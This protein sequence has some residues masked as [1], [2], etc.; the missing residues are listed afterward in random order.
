MYLTTTLS[1]CLCDDEFSIFTEGKYFKPQD[2]KITVT[3][4]AVC[5]AY[6]SLSK[7]KKVSPG[8]YKSWAKKSHLAA[9]DKKN[10]QKFTLQLVLKRLH[11]QMFSPQQVI[12]WKTDLI[13]W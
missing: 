8:R 13:F 10:G 12:P 5:N 7:I 3:R 11:L 1:L 4:F 6:V 2:F 9:E